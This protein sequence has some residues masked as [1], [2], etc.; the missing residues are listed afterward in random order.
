M[1]NIKDV[2]G[3]FDGLAVQVN[4]YASRVSTDSPLNYAKESENISIEFTDYI[5][6][7]STAML[8]QA[9]TGS[10]VNTFI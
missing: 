4:S 3:G 8:Q 5:Y 1:D 6:G 7:A 2:L 9:L 10:L